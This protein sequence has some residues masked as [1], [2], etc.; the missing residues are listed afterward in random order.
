MTAEKF[1]L[2]RKETKGGLNYYSYREV[3]RAAG[4]P[5]ARLMRLLKIVFDETPEDPRKWSNLGTM[6]CWHRR[7]RLGDRHEFSSPE[8]FWD[9]IERE[10]GQKNFI[11]LPLYLYDHGGLIMSDRPFSD[12]WDSGQVGWIYVSHDKIRKEFRVDEVTPEVR[13][14][15]LNILKAEIEEYNYYLQ[16]RVYGFMAYSWTESGPELEDSC[17]GFY[18]ENPSQ[19]GLLD[20]IPPEFVLVVKAEGSIH[21]GQVFV[22]TDGESKVFSSVREL[23]NYLE[24]NPSTAAALEA[25]DAFHSLVA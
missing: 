11:I 23:R 25:F 9:Y 20:Q 19:N 21:N 13:Q 8:E 24:Q 5:A 12:P 16:G 4:I 3:K 17:W 1:P 22:L 18:G 2:F 14:K 15:A 10:G 6:V 7:Y